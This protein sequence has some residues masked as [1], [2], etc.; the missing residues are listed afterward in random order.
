MNEHHEPVGATD[1]DEL[2]LGDWVAEGINALE[3]YLVKQAAFA[4][5]L[6]EREGQGRDDG[7][8]AG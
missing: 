5:F 8:G 4:V 7:N 2:W 3:R 1:V 6:A